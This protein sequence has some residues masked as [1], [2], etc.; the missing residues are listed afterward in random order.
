MALSALQ[1]VENSPE[2]SVRKP[3][4]QMQQTGEQT[5]KQGETEKFPM[6]HMRCYLVSSSKL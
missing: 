4:E 5:G 2:N 6:W 1:Q 3:T